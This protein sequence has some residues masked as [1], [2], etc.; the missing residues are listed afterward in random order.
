MF[1]ITKSGK[2]KKYVGEDKIVIIPKKVKVIG[3]RAF[4]SNTMKEVILP[5]K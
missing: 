2:L 5:K 3:F 1:E 4:S